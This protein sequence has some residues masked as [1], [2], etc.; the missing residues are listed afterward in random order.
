MPLRSLVAPAGQMAPCSSATVRMPSCC[1]LSQTTTHV[2]PAA[3]GTTTNSPVSAG[4]MPCP[5]GRAVCHACGPSRS[6][7]AVSLPA[8]FSCQ[9][10]QPS[11][12]CATCVHAACFHA[13]FGIK[14]CARN[15]RRQPVVGGRRC[16]SCSNAAQAC[17][18]AGRPHG[19]D[20]PRPAAPRCPA[21]RTTRSGLSGW[22]S[23]RGRPGA[24]P[25]RLP[26]EA[27]P[28]G[29]LGMG[30]AWTWMS[31]ATTRMQWQP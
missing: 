6:C 13:L 16:A 7:H 26:P 11:A 21:Q 19:A 27:H 18:S 9:L 2:W 31:W 1:C 10:D 17:R 8:P 25:A 23:G 24:T 30:R 14:R 12:V 3:G 29:R 28:A 4:I 20:P 5:L 15:D 22:P